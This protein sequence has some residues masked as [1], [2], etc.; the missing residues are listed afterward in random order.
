M[1]LAH[2]LDKHAILK[3]YAGWILSVPDWNFSLFY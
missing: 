2:W 1:A 3:V